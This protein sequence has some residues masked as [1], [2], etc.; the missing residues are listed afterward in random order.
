MSRW[1]FATALLLV[2]LLAVPAGLPF[3]ELSG[4]PH[5]WRAWTEFGRL[6]GLAGNTLGLVA[7]T[8]AL[9]L[10]A[11]AAG[12][13]LLYRTDLPF[14]GVG[15]IGPPAQF[16]VR[17]ARAQLLP[18]LPRVF[19]ASRTTDML[20]PAKYDDRRE[21]VVRCL[22]GIP[23]AE[24]QRVLGGEER[25]DVRSC[26]LRPEVGDEVSQVVLLL[27]PNRAIRN[28]H[29]HVLSRERSHRMV[30]VDPCIDPFRRLKL[31]PGRT[32]LD[33]DDGRFGC[34]EEREE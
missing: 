1:R 2:L 32:E 21:A 33:R 30:G 17:V 7:L 20:V 6:A 27:R 14:R 18:Q 10:P 25:D 34:A 3:L 22:V 19:D 13:V 8:L 9:A 28:H 23:K 4:T 29:A 5:A 31:R 26:Q 16:E 12:A 24:L 11:G 15:W